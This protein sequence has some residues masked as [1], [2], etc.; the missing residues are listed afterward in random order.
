VTISV[1]RAGAL[2][3]LKALRGKHLGV[4]R[5]FR[6]VKVR[7][8]GALRTVATFAPPL[9]ASVSP[10]TATGRS[11]SNFP[12]SVL[13]TAA[14][15]VVGGQAPFAY[16]WAKVSGATFV[17]TS[18]SSASTYFN[19]PPLGPGQTA[20]AIYRCTVTD[21][22]GQTAQGNVNLIATNH[23]ENP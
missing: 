20:Q 23:G 21:A 12:V 8:G 2:R 22:L 11:Y 3:P 6:T 19:S 10:S 16:S 9:T 14:C 17:V 5:R 1:H 4:V 7:H 18:P 13:T 15:S